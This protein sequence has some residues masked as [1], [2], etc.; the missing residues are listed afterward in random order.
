MLTSGCHDHRQ[1]IERLLITVAIGL[2]LL[3]I[4]AFCGVLVRVFGAILLR[5]IADPIGRVLP[6]GDFG[7]VAITVLLVAA[8]L[9]VF[10]CFLGSGRT[11]P[12]PETTG[13]TP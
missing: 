1:Y 13:N 2:A 8:V 10:T 5:A 6:I 3:F 7:A 11:R 12:V 4:W 9:G